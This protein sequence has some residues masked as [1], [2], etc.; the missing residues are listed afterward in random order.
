MHCSISLVD[1]QP[2]AKC[3]VAQKLSWDDHP[4]VNM[5]THSA[6]IGELQKRD[7]EIDELVPSTIQLSLCEFRFGTPFRTIV[8]ALA[9]FSILNF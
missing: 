2:F 4:D 9:S 1:G 8:N 6:L 5:T 3:D 7:R